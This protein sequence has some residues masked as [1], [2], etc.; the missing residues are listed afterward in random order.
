M[1]WTWYYRVLTFIFTDLAIWDNSF[2]K[3][4]CLSVLCL[5]VCLCVCAIAET[6]L[7]GGLDTFVTHDMGPV[8]HA[9]WPLIHDT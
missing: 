1:E 2:L 5:S 8:T 4:Q 6:P 9:I 3:L 7:P